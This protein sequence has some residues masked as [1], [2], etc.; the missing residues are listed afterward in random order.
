MYS[1]RATI[2]DTGKVLW[3]PRVALD[4]VITARKK[5]HVEWMVTEKI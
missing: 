1:F 4:F 2:G 5:V 3:G